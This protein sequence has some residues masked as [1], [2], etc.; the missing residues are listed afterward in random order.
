MTLHESAEKRNIT[1]VAGSFSF[2]C[3]VAAGASSRSM[4][5]LR[6]MNYTSNFACHDHGRVEFHD[7]D[8]PTVQVV[9]RAP[10]PRWRWKARQ[11][12]LPLIFRI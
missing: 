2:T 4:M 11:L 10:A 9:S 8:R 5:Q 6:V 3:L 7:R 12:R 1:N